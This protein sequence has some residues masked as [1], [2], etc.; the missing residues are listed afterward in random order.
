MFFSGFVSFH[1]SYDDHVSL[2]VTEVMHADVNCADT[3]AKRTLFVQCTNNSTYIYIIIVIKTP[4]EVNY[5]L[6][7]LDI[8]MPHLYAH[9]R[10]VV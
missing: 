1:I 4:R 5:S 6:F 8:I 9:R 7:A 2:G 3:C 10:V